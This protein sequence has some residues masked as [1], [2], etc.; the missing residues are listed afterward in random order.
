[1]V[2]LQFSKADRLVI[3]ELVTG[4]PKSMPDLENQLR[5]YKVSV[6]HLV[7]QFLGKWCSL[8]SCCERPRV[9]VQELRVKRAA[10]RSIVMNP[11]SS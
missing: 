10:K 1:M 9:S 7:V 2:Y 8:A 6:I 4:L 5:Y 3:S 11:G